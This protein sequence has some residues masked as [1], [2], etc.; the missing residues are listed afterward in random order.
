MSEMNL[1]TTCTSIWR[2]REQDKTRRD[3]HTIWALSVCVCRQRNR[4]NTHL[5]GHII[6]VCLL[7][8]L[9]FF[10]L[11][12]LPDAMVMN[13]TATRRR[14]CPKFISTLSL[15]ES[16]SKSS[17]PRS[18]DRP[19][20]T[21]AA[22]LRSNEPQLDYFK[23]VKSSRRNFDITP[24]KPWQ[25][26]QEQQRSSRGAGWWWG[27]AAAAAPPRRNLITKLSSSTSSSSSPHGHTHF[28]ISNTTQQLR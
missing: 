17:P 15:Q 8:F 21:E 26:Q 10:F 24:R 13:E 9:F 23:R 2:D 12:F 14:K 1:N 25:Q 16:K 28:F 19:D 20:L 3:G 22:P 18:S 4:K 11:F 27:A 5:R 6:I 7:L